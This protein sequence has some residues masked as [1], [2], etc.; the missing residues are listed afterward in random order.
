M[1]GL[2]EAMTEAVGPDTAA[3]SGSEP[4]KAL[5]KKPGIMYIAE[6]D[7]VTGLERVGLTTRKRGKMG[8]LSWSVGYGEEK[9]IS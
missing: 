1:A 3:F 4:Q 2:A 5:A 6:G 7:E 9:N 8:K